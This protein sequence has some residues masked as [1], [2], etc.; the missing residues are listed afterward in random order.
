MALLHRDRSSTATDDTV[1]GPG[2][3]QRPA[4]PEPADHHHDDD[5]PA[6]VRRNSV[7]QTIRT[8]VATIILVAVVAVAIANTDQV[9]VDLLFETVEASLAALVGGAAVAGLLIGVLLGRGSRHK[10]A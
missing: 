9:D 6:V 5:K 7:G 10:N 3:A 4:W 2:T 1:A 8:V